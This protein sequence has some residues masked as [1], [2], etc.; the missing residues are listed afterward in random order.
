MTPLIFKAVAAYAAITPTERGGYAIAKAAR[1]L[2]PRAKWN[3]T[4]LTPGGLRL[5]L[6]LATYPDVCMAMGL[7]ELDTIRI[8]RKLLKPGNWFVDGGANLGYFTLTA[9]QLV[10]PTGKIDSYEPDP[11]NRQ[12]LESH[13][14]ANGSPP[15][16]KI[17][18][19]ALSDNPGTIQIIHPSTTTGDNHGTAS[20]YR[21]LVP[22]GQPHDVPTIRLDQ[23]LNGVPDVI[24]L[25]VEGA[26]LSAINGMATLLNA[27]NPPTLIVE[28]NQHTSAPPLLWF[29]H[30]RS[31]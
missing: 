11:V 14:L 23:D 20:I 12:R 28:H 16:V 1:K 9:A 19:A 8:L 30:G 17:H 25:D 24:K 26:E 27:P 15:F 31:I 5:Q 4:F 22:N 3:N 10:G 29:H 2:I 7:Y 18:P 6:D 13:L 21:S